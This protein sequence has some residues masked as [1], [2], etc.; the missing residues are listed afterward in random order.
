MIYTNSNGMIYDETNKK[1]NFDSSSNNTNNN[2]NINVPQENYK[3]EKEH[4][5]SNKN[6]KFN[7]TYLFIMLI[8]I[9]LIISICCVSSIFTPYPQIQQKSADM[10]NLIQGIT[11][12]SNYNHSIQP[13]VIPITITSPQHNQI[14]NTYQTPN[15]FQNQYTPYQQQSY[16]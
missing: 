9:S 12:T 16:Y 8:S 4:I 3:I 11:D 1:E 2:S 10:N 13:F 15:N 7:N 14:P 6:T 5:N